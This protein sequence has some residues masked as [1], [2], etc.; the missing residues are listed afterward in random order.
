MEKK[1]YK[2]AIVGDPELSAIFRTLGCDVYPA[3]TKDEVYNTILTMK[4]P[5]APHSYG[6]VFV[7]EDVLE[8]LSE[9]EY[10]KITEGALPSI[11]AVPSPNKE[12]TY[13][14]TKLKKLTEQALGQDL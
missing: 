10:E 7:F 14:V 3:F 6:I 11:V 12:S 1:T 5:D 13:S 2:I 9:E 4:L 8:R